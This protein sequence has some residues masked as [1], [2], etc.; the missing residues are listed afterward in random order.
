VTT[1]AALAMNLP[2]YDGARVHGAEL[3][4]GDI[5]RVVSH[6]ASLNLAGRTAMP[7]LDPG[8]ADVIV[9]GGVIALALLEHWGVRSLRASDRGVRWGLAHE[10]LD[11]QSIATG[12]AAGPVDKL[13]GDN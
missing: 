1:L 12:G 4:T 10:L 6:L 7:A 5:E 8:R 3:L 9:A 13:A 2:A 11:R